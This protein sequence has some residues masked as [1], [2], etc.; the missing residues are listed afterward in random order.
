[1]TASNRF[2]SLGKDSTGVVNMVL[3]GRIPAC[4]RRCA[5]S[6]PGGEVAAPSAR[7]TTPDEK[8]QLQEMHA[9]GMGRNA[10]MRAMGEF[11]RS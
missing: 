1:M 5:A 10:I 3:I 11:G 8:R 6:Q 7:P 4:H 2:G 9:A